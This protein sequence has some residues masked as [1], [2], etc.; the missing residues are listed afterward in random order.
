MCMASLGLQWRSNSQNRSDQQ[1]MQHAEQFAAVQSMYFDWRVD[2][3]A[4]NSY[5]CNDSR[6]NQHSRWLQLCSV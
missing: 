5:G 1:H 2:V 6:V 3:D 4:V